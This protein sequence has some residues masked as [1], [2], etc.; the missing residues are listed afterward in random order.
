LRL[1]GAQ[2]KAP[3]KRQEVKLDKKGKV[4]HEPLPYVTLD[5]EEALDRAYTNKLLGDCF[6]G[7]FAT[8]V[9]MLAEK[10]GGPYL[11]YPTTVTRVGAGGIVGWG[12]TC[13]AI[14]GAAMAI[15]LVSPDPTPIIDEVFNHYQYTALPDV[16]PK[17]AK[18]DIAPSTA[19]STLCHVSIS[20]WTKVSGAKAFSK[21]RTERCAHLAAVV[22]RKTVSALNAQMAGSFQAAFPIPEE[23][24]KC[25]SCHDM[26]G[27]MENTRG[28]MNCLTCHSGHDEQK[29]NIYEVPPKKI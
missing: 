26:G 10:V 17:N 13:G 23:V 9:E 5:P 21:E 12:T 6:Y 27:E 20:H 25:R 29:P 22:T 4:H 2:D 15:Y 14:Q 8:V 11:T 16:K 18:M 1:A 7:V 3:T 19:G 24:K 28:K